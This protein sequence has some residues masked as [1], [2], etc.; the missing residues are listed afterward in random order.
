MEI[1]F[2]LLSNIISCVLLSTQSYYDTG[3]HPST[4]TYVR[5]K[6]ICI[7]V[8]LP[9]FPPF[10][11]TQTNNT[12]I[13]PGSTVSI[14]FTVATTTNGVV[15]DSATG[16][17]TVRANND[18]S[19]SSTSPSTITIA[20][21][22]GGKA[23]GTVTLTVPASASSGTQVTLTIEAENTAATDINYAVLRFSV[24]AKVR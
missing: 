24:A 12:N 6:N 19:Y 5:N 7:N 13:E 11:Q 23:N 22:S 17:F 14:P 20:A 1:V 15:N 18:R 4:Y 8:F 9:F 16:T 2:I 10:F 3:K 21:D